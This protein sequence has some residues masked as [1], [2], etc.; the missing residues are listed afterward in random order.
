MREPFRP[1]RRDGAE[2]SIAD[3]VRRRLCREFL[4][5]AIDALVAGIYAGDP[6]KPLK[7]AVAP[8]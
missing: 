6:E 4:D 8:A 2:E 1:A 7:H 3:F 5:H